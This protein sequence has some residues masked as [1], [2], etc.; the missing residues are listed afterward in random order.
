LWPTAIDFAQRVWTRR[1]LPSPQGQS[2]D[3]HEYRWTDI[4]VLGQFPRQGC[5]D[6]AFSRQD[7]RQLALRYDLSRIALFQTTNFDQVAQNLPG[8][9]GCNGVVIDVT[10]RYQFTGQIEQAWQL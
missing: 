6:L 3:R 10:F 5:A 9:G 7:G 8:L 1:Q 2:S 4:E